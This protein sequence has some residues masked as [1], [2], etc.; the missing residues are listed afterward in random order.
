[1]GLIQIQS[2]IDTITLGINFH[3]YNNNIGKIK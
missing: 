2:I 1:T 3:I